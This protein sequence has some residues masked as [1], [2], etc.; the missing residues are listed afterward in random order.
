MDKHALCSF[1]VPNL[2]NYLMSQVRMKS[3]LFVPWSL[4]GPRTSSSLVWPIV[5]VGRLQCVNRVIDPMVR[6]SQKSSEAV[7]LLRK[8]DA[9]HVC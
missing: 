4:A 8:S 6:H 1:Q 3:S 2:I 5:T 7:I 9:F